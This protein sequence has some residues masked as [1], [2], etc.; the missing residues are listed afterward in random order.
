MESVGLYLMASSAS[1]VTLYLRVIAA[2]LGALIVA[3]VAGVAL[4][5]R[6]I[7]RVHERRFEERSTFLRVESGRRSDPP[8]RE[9]QSIGFHPP[10][11]AHHPPR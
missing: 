2:M 4:V 3:T 8:P 9:K 11:S 7:G 5:L 1:D 6:R 10:P